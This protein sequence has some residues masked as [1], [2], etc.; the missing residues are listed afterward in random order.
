MNGQPSSHMLMLLLGKS[1][2]GESARAE[3]EYLISL[4]PGCYEGV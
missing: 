4:A 3:E 2:L 1:G